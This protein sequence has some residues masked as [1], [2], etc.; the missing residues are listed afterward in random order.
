[1]VKLSG[2]VVSTGPFTI[3]ISEVVTNE[4]RLSAKQIAS[5]WDRPLHEIEKRISKMGSNPSDKDL[6]RF[7]EWVWN[8]GIRSDVRLHTASTG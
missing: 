3:S 8:G 1:M 5:V 6:D 7:F 2:N 4:Y